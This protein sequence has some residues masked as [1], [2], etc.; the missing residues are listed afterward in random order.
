MDELKRLLGNV[1]N[2]KSGLAADL[3]KLGGVLRCKLCGHERPLQAGEAGHFT[4]NGWPKHCGK[5]MAWVTQKLLDEE[6][7]DTRE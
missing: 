5:T 1:Q 4:F 7:E 3:D 6:A 2:F